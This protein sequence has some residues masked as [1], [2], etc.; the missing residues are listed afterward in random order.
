VHPE[1]L[2]F[3]SAVVSLEP[4]ACK[5]QMSTV[6]SYYLPFLQKCVKLLDN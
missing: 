6:F 3:F 2:W 1:N 4:Q 5:D